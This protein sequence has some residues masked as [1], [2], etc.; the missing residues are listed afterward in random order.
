MQISTASVLITGGASGLGEAVVRSVLQRGGRALIADLDTVRGEALA[1]GLG[2]RALFVQTDV[3]QTGAVNAAITALVNRWGRLDAAVNCAGI[4]PP[5]RILGKDGPLPLEEFSRVI[6]VN[7]GGTFN[8]C[9]LAAEAMAANEP[10]PDGERG[11]LINTA[12]VAAFEGQIGQCAYAASKA[13]V[14]GLTLPMAR[15]LA[16]HGIRVMAIAPGLF[17]T[18]LLAGLPEEARHSLAATIPFPARLG[19]PDEFA[20]LAVHILENRYLNGEVIRLD[21]SLRMG[22]K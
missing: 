7:L 13:G 19:D 11:V 9:R 22:P 17:D 15:D 2:E 16:R 5:R 21:A 6:Q 4:A 14:A 1:A 20:A 18:P 12:S 8:V 10:H 3:T